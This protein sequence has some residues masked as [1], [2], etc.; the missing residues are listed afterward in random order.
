M[1]DTAGDGLSCNN[2]FL[3][4][5]NHVVEKPVKVI[6]NKSIRCARVASKSDCQHPS[7]FTR[8]LPAY[9]VAL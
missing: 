2:H 4:G 8:Y 1:R 6:I 9:I 5:G 3:G 7:T